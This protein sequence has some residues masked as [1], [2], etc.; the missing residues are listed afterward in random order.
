MIII[1]S[2]VLNASPVLNVT[3]HWIGALLESIWIMWMGGCCG[4]KRLLD[5]SFGGWGR[6]FVVCDLEKGEGV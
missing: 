5:G 1:I 2:D 3:I 4:V 6:G